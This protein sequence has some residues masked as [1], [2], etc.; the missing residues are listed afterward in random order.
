M[1]KKSPERLAAICATIASGIT[2][3]QRASRM[4]DI[5]EDTF[6]NWVKLSQKNPADE[7]LRVDYLNERV[8]FAIA[9]HA[10]R[11]VALHE[12]RGRM[13]QKSI[14]GFD[15]PIFYQGMPTWK[16][17]PRCVGMDEE[18]RDMLG[19]PKDG[20]LRDERGNCIQNTIHHEPP[21]ALQLRVAEMAFP[22][23]YRPGTTVESNI[24]HNGVVGIRHAPPTNYNGGPPPVPPAPVPPQLTFAPEQPDAELDEMLALPDDVAEIAELPDE[25]DEAAPPVDVPVPS[26]PAPMA[27]SETPK[28]VPRTALEADLF[29]KL[30]AAR[31]KPKGAANV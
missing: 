16:P 24:T 15:E 9:V 14:L 30:E 18:T 3:Y 11:R 23:E 27:V 7:S 4:N 17:D 8:P 12:M 2:S 6:W 28:R 5:D 21:I 22:R 1:T 25:P 31:T 19:F 10:A 29:A 26:T 13:E 20:L